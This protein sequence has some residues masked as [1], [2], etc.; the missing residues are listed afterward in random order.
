MWRWEA[1]LFDCMRAVGTIN[2]RSGAN[3]SRVADYCFHT[4][5]ITASAGSRKS[6]IKHNR[7]ITK[8]S[9][10]PAR[11]PPNNKECGL[12]GQRNTQPNRQITATNASSTDFHHTR[13]A[14]AK[15]G[16]SINP[17]RATS[18]ERRGGEGRRQRRRTGSSEMLPCRLSN[19]CFTY[20]RSQLPYRGLATAAAGEGEGNVRDAAAAAS[21]ESPSGEAQYSPMSPRLLGSPLPPPPPGFPKVRSARA[22][23]CCVGRVAGERAGGACAFRRWVWGDG[24]LERAR[25]RGGHEKG[26]A[27]RVAR[28]FRI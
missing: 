5:K 8:A 24:K 14:R 15:Q 7:R 18:Q 1:S 6:R 20:R 9:H 2:R 10:N 12:W 23:S 26:E 16:S 3:P 17:R 13:T 22:R 11:R 21:A 27:G 28:G 25:K 4:T 19:T